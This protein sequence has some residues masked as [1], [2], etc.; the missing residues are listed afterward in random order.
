M[1]WYGMLCY[2]MV[3]HGMLCYDLSLIS[4]DDMSIN[5][6]YTYMNGHR[7]IC[8]HI[9]ISLPTSLPTYPPTFMHIYP[10]TYM[11]TYPPTPVYIS[12]PICFCYLP[13]SVYLSAFATYPP[14]PHWRRHSGQTRSTRDPD[15]HSA[16]RKR[17]PTLANPAKPLNRNGME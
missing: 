4:F 2:G 10:P 5:T 3:C 12:V 14:L 9:P 1:I 8:A 13:T 6:Q 15:R 7:Y 17:P 11:H 16:F